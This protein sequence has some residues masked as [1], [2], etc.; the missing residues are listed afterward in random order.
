MSVEGDEDFSQYVG[1]RGT[2]LLRSALLLGCAPHE[3]ED[4]V[5]DTLAACY[6]SWDRVRRAHERDAYVYRVLI[7][8]H[9]KSRRRRWWGEEPTS[10]LPEVAITDPVQRLDEAHAL[11]SALAALSPVNRSAVVLRYYA[12]LSEAETAQ[13]LGI[14]RGTVKSRLSRA[15]TQLSSDPN[16]TGLQAEAPHE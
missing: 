8:M 7:N 9:A 5:Q 6:A 10:D 1:A 3:A 11:R 4:L 14:T 2:S 16:L 12:Q 13:A 15:L